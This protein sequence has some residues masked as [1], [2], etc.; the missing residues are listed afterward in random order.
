MCL[1][2]DLFGNEIREP[3]PAAVERAKRKGT[4]ANGYA[5]RPGSGPQGETCGTCRNLVRKVLSKNYYK[6]GLVRQ[7]WTGGRGSDV[8]VKAEA[9]SRWERWENPN[10]RRE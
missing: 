9:C 2:R 5:G 7:F 4:P 3:A 8:L 1:D 10:A 6:C